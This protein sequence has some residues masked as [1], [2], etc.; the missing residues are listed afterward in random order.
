MRAADQRDLV[1][2]RNHQVFLRNV[3]QVAEPNLELL[4]IALDAGDGILG[5]AAVAAGERDRIDQRLPIGIE[6]QPARSW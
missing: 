3:E 5:V 2:R 4:A 6:D 1:A